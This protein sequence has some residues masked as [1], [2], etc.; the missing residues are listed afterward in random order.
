M[1]MDDALV[2]ATLVADARL[3][4]YQI[5]VFQGIY[6]SQQRARERASELDVFA[7]MLLHT[8]PC[9]LHY[10]PPMWRCGRLWGSALGQLPRE[11]GCKLGI[12]QSTCFLSP[13]SSSSLDEIQEGVRSPKV[14]RQ[15]GKSWQ[16]HHALGCYIL[17]QCLILNSLL[18]S[19][20][21]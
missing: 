19:R 7:V 2:P 15:T 21:S 13:F 17:R 16:M 12:A 8:E 18:S 5:F 3:F 20:Q 6:S 1:P 14:K 9:T 10:W 4:H 11:T